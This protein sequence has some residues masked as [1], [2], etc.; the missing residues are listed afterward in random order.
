MEGPRETEGQ[1]PGEFLWLVFIPL[2][3]GTLF[4]G[5]TCLLRTK[6][7]YEKTIYAPMLLLNQNE[8]GTGDKHGI[9]YMPKGAF[10]WIRELLKYDENDVL[11]TRG[12][13]KAVFLM[14]EK[15]IIKLAL[16]FSVLGWA[17][18][19]PI[20]TTSGGTLQPSID[21]WFNKVSLSR[22]EAKSS[23]LWA[24]MV[25]CYLFSFITFW[26][27]V[28]LTQNIAKVR[29]QSL[30]VGEWSIKAFSTLVRD[31]P[32]QPHKESSE[33][34]SDPKVP[35]SSASK[36]AT[37]AK[38]LK[39]SIMSS[40]NLR[41]EDVI[42][43]FEAE[44]PGEIVQ[45]SCMPTDT[46]EVEKL[47]TR[48]QKNLNK[49]ARAKADYEISDGQG[50]LL[51]KKNAPKLDSSIPKQAKKLEEIREKYIHYMEKTSK[52]KVE[53]ERLQ[54]EALDQPVAAAVVTFKSR[55]TAVLAG[56]SLHASDGNLWLASPAEEPGAMVWSN[57]SIKKN[58]RY[59]AS[60]FASFVLILLIFFWMIPVF[61]VASLTTL[62]NLEKWLPFVKDL[63]KWF[64]GFLQGF[65]PGLA[66]LLFNLLLLPICR[67]LTLMEGVP[68]LSM[69]ESG[70]ATKLFLFSV[71]NTFLGITVMSSIL[72]ELDTILNGSLDFMDVVQL[73]GEA[74]PTTAIFFL[75]YILI[76]SWVGWPLDLS[77]LVSIIVYHIKVRFLCRKEEEIKDTVAADGPLFPRAISKNLFILLVAVV[78]STIHPLVPPFAALSML[79]GYFVHLNNFLF[80]TS[81][82][83][84]ESGGLLWMPIMQKICWILVLAQLTLAGV[85]LLK[86][87]PIAAALLVPLVLLTYG[88][89]S[90]LFNR[91]GRA[92]LFVPLQIVSDLDRRLTDSVGRLEN[93]PV[94][95][96]ALESQPTSPEGLLQRG[97]HMPCM[98]PPESLHHEVEPPLLDAP[99]L[100]EEWATPF[101]N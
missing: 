19:A 93:E 37:F 36:T 58:Q 95:A 15:L 53:L 30:S 77:R 42:R 44:F 12:A 28:N 13:D 81:R 18:L 79:V 17:I 34:V 92:M 80:V 50:F 101:G 91:Y 64:L 59:A 82:N 87:S 63:P 68:N 2:S 56:Q 83:Q 21:V 76:Q 5:L 8:D 7:T 54:L 11:K 22:V 70:T 84:Y 39:S 75:N 9:Q 97:Y 24:S 35:P 3:V 46:K 23:R 27:L 98:R 6:E 26:F 29:I 25:M 16:I 47:W 40:S 94:T 73:L 69:L 60:K 86:E 20:Y 89:Y 43:F 85:L 48:Y 61:F 31:L 52:M 100:P 51:L 99:E 55:K 62:S 66:L 41:R 74:V 96:D 32:S 33:A 90:Y 38:S 4:V 78:F 72:T 49:L 71:F 45:V 65:L 88:F 14:V 1:T 10:A 57:L 67:F